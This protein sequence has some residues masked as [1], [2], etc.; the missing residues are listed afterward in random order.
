MA[1][2]PSPEVI[3]PAEGDLLLDLAEVALDRALSGDRPELPALPALTDLPPVLRGAGDAFVTLHVAGELNGCIGAL[4]TGEPLGHAVV[5]LALAAAF[6][7]PRLPALR[8]GD[9]THLAIEV[10]LLSPRSPIPARSLDELAAALHPGRDGVVV[11]AGR[12][13]GLFLP[14]VWDQLPDPHA[15]LAR[16]WH[17]SGLRPGAWPNGLVASRFHTQRH[18][19]HPSPMTSPPERRPWP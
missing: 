17:K 14:D 13:R 5:R 8:P 2:S 4:D 18:E 16:L 12:R 7:D 19:R 9:R 1:P 10:S 15:F 6:D 3:S 11:R